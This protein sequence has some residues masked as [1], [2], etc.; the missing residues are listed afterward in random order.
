MK[1][2]HQQLST[3]ALQTLVEEFVTRDGTDYGDLEVSLEQKTT[4]VIRMLDKG[5]VVILFDADSESCNIVRKH[6]VN[7]A[8]DGL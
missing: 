6:E 7:D 4:R 1:I 3:D 2:P 5:D 8:T